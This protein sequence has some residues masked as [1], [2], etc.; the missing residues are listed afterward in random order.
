MKKCSKQ[1]YLKKC[2]KSDCRGFLNNSYKCELCK[3]VAC[4][5]CFEIKEENHVCN[6]DNVKTAELLRKDTKSCP[7]CSE[8]IHKIEG[9]NQ[10]FC[11][12]CGTGFDWK[13]LKIVTGVIHNP[14]YFEYHSKNGGIPRTIG[15]I[16][17]G[18]LPSMD[19]ILYKISQVFNIDISLI[20]NNFAVRYYN[21]PRQEK[22][23]KDYPNLQIPVKYL[24]KF[25][26]VSKT[27][28]IRHQKLQ[29]FKQVQ[30]F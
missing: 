9:C 30:V 22:L 21:I 20:R 12:S 28:H 24:R 10:M 19:A 8:M 11:V 29:I 2:P 1:N 17:C 3:T 6:E 26:M 13:T 5:K 25:K 14:H 18:G 15:D 27:T 16:P 7:N 4:S 23:L